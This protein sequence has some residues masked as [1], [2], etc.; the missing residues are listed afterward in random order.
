MRTHIR[1]PTILGVALTAFFLGLAVPSASE[2]V[3]AGPVFSSGIGNPAPK[4]LHELDRDIGLDNTAPFNPAAFSEPVKMSFENA[5]ERALQNQRVMR[6]AHEKVREARGREWQMAS[7]LLPHLTAS[8]FQERTGRENLAAL[9]FQGEGFPQLIGPFNT[10]DARFELTQS[11]LNLSAFARFQAGKSEV[12]AA[13]YQEELAHQQVVLITAAAYLEALRSYSALKAAHADLDLARRLLRQAE[14][15][16]EAGVANGVDVARAD[17]R[18]AQ[19]ELRYENIRRSVQDAYLD[20]QRVTGLSYSSLVEF[21]DSLAFV[22]DPPPPAGEA[23][24]S[25]LENRMEIGAARE[26]LHADHELEWAAR[27]ERF[28]RV[29]FSGNYGLSGTGPDK[30]ARQTG[31]GLLRVSVPIFEGGKIHGDAEEASSR[32]KQQEID[33][34]DLKRQIEEDVYKALWTLQTQTD[35]VRAAGKVVLLA[36]RELRLAGDRFTQGVGDNIEVLNAQTAL[37]QAR[38]GYIT[39]LAQYHLARI[40]F[41]FA[42]GRSGSFY[43]PKIEKS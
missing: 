43:L 16:A 38:E 40:N 39:A 35:Q 5:V 7:E 19:E 42:L 17:T 9:G 37:A 27:G 2:K 11:L 4:T 25:A 15:Q 28:P 1:K 26:I 29:D 13:G 20:F 24:A 21:Q 18:A 32:K 31:A 30:S 3:S 34:E 22:E 10:F 36:K 23:V 8:A 12:R 14:H 33:L 6:L 41:Y